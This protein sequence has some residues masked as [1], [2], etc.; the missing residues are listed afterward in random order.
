[1]IS[2]EVSAIAR[3]SHETAGEMKA[4]SEFANEIHSGMGELREQVAENAGL[5][6]KL[7]EDAASSGDLASEN[8]VST[9]SQ[10]ASSF[11]GS[12]AELF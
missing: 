6:K 7:A 11:A 10:L 5:S 9:L 2:Q 3:R 4:Q 12:D 1:M 8:E